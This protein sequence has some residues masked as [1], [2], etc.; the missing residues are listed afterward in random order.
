MLDEQAQQAQQVQAQTGRIRVPVKI[1][2]QFTPVKQSEKIG[3]NGRLCFLPKYCS[4]MGSDLQVVVS[5]K[6]FL[7]GHYSHV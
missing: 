4:E 3:P 1:T 5:L 7:N 2:V 6:L